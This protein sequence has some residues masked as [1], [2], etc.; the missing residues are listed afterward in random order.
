M[1]RKVPITAIAIFLGHFMILPFASAEVFKWVDDKG[2][3]HF[4]EDESNIPEKYRQ[5]TE[6]RPLP[7][8]PGSPREKVKEGKEEKKGSARRPPA[9]SKE[10]QQVNVKRIES[11]VTDSFKNIISLWKDKKDDALYDCGDRKS[12]TQVAKEE[13][14]GRRERKKGDP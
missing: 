12:R 13:F 8:D 6:K 11:D 9:G 5:Q 7:E 4:T 3:I 10:K 14:R 1:R 2:T